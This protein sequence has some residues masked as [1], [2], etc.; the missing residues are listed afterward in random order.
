VIALCVVTTVM[1]NSGRGRYAPLTIIPMLFVIASTMTAGYQMIAGKFLGMVSLGR[2]QNNQA[3]LIQ[4]ILNIA[5]T[6]FM[7]AAVIIILSQAVTR[8]VGGR[9]IEP[10]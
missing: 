10:E 1:F 7:I 5:L 6:A 3:L 9:G 8:W 2:S 4:G